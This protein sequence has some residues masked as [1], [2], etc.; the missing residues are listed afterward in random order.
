MNLYEKEQQ[1]IRMRNG[2]CVMRAITFLKN[3]ATEHELCRHFTTLS[4]THKIVKDELRRILRNG[5]NC[6]FLTKNENKYMLSSTWNEYQ[7]D[8]DEWEIEDERECDGWKIEDEEEERE[9]NGEGEEEDCSTEREADD[10]CK[11]ETDGPTRRK[12]MRKY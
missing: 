3:K 10:V 11:E 9:S 1:E 7:V 12:R 8:A 5:C 4:G 6:G 2:Q